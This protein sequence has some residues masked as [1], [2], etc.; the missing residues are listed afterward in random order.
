[1]I[2]DILTLFPKMFSGVFEES[3]IKL[4]QSKRLIEI[5]VVNIRD[6]SQDKHKKV[7]DKPYGGGAGMVL[8]PGPV[9][10]AV[11]HALG[12]DVDSLA[13]NK[14][15]KSARVV[16]LTPQG[17]KLNQGVA[18]KLS[19]YKHLILIAGHYE[20]FDERIRR[21]ATDEISI[22]DYILTGGELPAMVLL[23]SIARLVPGV[24]G[25]KES[26]PHESFESIIL[27]HPQYTRPSVFC[28]LK[29]PEILLSG[30]HKDIEAWRIEQA[31]KKTKKV[32]PDLWE[33]YLKR[34]GRNG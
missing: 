31:L 26:V 13:E 6:F 12:R 33:E 4:A 9:F 21:M 20:G 29:V 11:A 8:S 17:K 23:D 14:S 27:E 25:N 15:S 2:I 24:L 22:G 19:K 28:G 18:R 1:M 16:L 34:K 5:N 7:D 30:R 32:R 3:I 10:R